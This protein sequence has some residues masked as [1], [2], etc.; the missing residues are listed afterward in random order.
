MLTEVCQLSYWLKRRC[1]FANLSTVGNQTLADKNDKDQP[2]RVQPIASSTL[3]HSDLTSVYGTVVM[4]R[5]VLFLGT[6]NG[7]LLKWF[8]CSWPVF[9]DAVVPRGGTELQLQAAEEET[10]G[11]RLTFLGICTGYTFKSHICGYVFRVPI[12]S[13]EC[14]NKEKEAMRSPGQDLGPEV[15]GGA[16]TLS[17]GNRPKSKGSGNCQNLEVGSVV[18]C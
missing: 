10:A 1:A 16:R 4:N 12:T 9:S 18:G 17:R 6:G 3:I 15:G 2:E 8:V 11:P 14:S 5:T 7:Q 13:A